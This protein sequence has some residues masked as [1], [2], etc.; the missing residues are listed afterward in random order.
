[1][2]ESKMPTYLLL[3]PKIKA[4]IKDKPAYDGGCLHIN[5]H[6]KRQIIPLCDERNTF[7]HYAEKQI[8][9]QRRKPKK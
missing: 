3:N 7:P 5:K 9:K 8:Q 2:M 6:N 1:M 4:M